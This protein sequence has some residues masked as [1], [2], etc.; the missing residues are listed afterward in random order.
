MKLKAFY[1]VVFL[2]F[3][4]LMVFGQSK[5]I[6][7]DSLHNI[8]AKANNKN[9][10]AISYNNLSKSF[11][12][13]IPDSGLFYAHKAVVLSR[14]I[15]NES[16][17]SYAYLYLGANHKN[18][19]SND[20]ALFYLDKAIDLFEKTKNKPG[21]V[22]AKLKKALI[23]DDNGNNE[24]AIN[25]VSGL[26]ND[27]KT[28]AI[29]IELI[30][31]YSTLGLIHFNLGGFADSKTLFQ[32]AVSLSTK[33]N[34]RYHIAFNK[35]KLGYAM[36]KLGQPDSAYAEYEAALAIATNLKEEILKATI[37][38]L[39]GTY[40]LD[41]SDYSKSLEYFYESLSI[42][43]R[44]NAKMQL[45]KSYT[46][47]GLVY[48]NQKD[49]E[50]A[51][52]NFK[53][54]L[55]RALE[56]NDLRTAGKLYG[57]IG[58]VYKQ[59]K[60]YNKTLDFYNKALEIAIKRNDKYE[61]ARTLG[62][63]GSLSQSMCKYVDAVEYMRRARRIKIELRAIRDLIYDVQNL[64]Y[65]NFLLSTDSVRA[66]LGPLNPSFLKSKEYHQN[67][68]IYLLK[69]CSN[70]VD[71]IDGEK[72]QKLY[73]VGN[74]VWVYIQMDDYKNAF[75][76]HLELSNLEK[77]INNETT[78]ER[79][80]ELEAVQEKLKT[81]KELA[82]SIEREQIQQEASEKRQ[83]LI[84]LLII[85]IGLLLFLAILV[86]RRYQISKKQN[87]IIAEQKEKLTKLDE[88]KNN[89]FTN[90]THEFRT[91][92]TVILGA[93][94]NIENSEDSN[95]IKRN[96]QRLLNLINQ[97]LD[98]SKLED[99]SLKINKKQI[100]AV[101]FTKYLTDSY[102]S[103]ALS[104]NK[105]LEFKS[106]VGEQF[107][108]L[109]EDKYQTIIGNLVSNAVKFTPKNGDIKI[110]TNSDGQQLNISIKDS[111]DG[112]PKDELDRLFDR[113]YQ[114]KG[115]KN[116]KIGSGV[117]L[118]L[119]KE[120]VLQFNGSISV[121]N[122]ENGGAIFTVSL[123]ITKQA[124]KVDFTA[125]ARVGIEKASIEI[126][127]DE[128]EDNNKPILLLVEDEPDIQSFIKA[129]LANNYNLLI[130]NNGEEGIELALANVPDI[131]L[132]DVMMPG[133]DGL[134]LTN[135]L[136][137]DARTSHIP[138]ALLTAKVDLES[139]LQGLKRGADVYLPKPFER[140]E[141]LLQLS[142]LQEQQK[143]VRQ[144]FGA[145]KVETPETQIIEAIE[146]EDEF[147]TKL[148]ETISANFEN[149]SFGI[150]EL[151]ST[152][153]MSRTQ[154][155]RKLKALTGKSA[156]QFVNEFKIEKACELLMLPDNNV[157]E[158]A[159]SLGFADPNY[160]TRVFTKIKGQ[161]PTEFL[162]QHR[163]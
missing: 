39:L 25:L 139:R 111:G 115:S 54:G 116:Q 129:T 55:E 128:I 11:L 75:S 69:R 105:T 117:G 145:S 87:S 61:E 15:K 142:N 58:I 48:L 153:S 12:N 163:K 53:I 18:A 63:L 125:L 92:L 137:N 37:I 70:L 134:E 123:P 41:N 141:L 57:N 67:R 140:E 7:S 98:L 35:L 3:P 157:S 150:E 28:N 42:R 74:L 50:K 152:I 147:I 113:F 84:Y 5:S 49:T 4:V 124:Q 59:Q 51:I 77:Q 9:D 97:I 162:E 89:F 78:T 27:L 20:S 101:A 23:L 76:T 43:Q 151:S 160:F 99:G 104:Q 45:S 119:T 102:K 83:N 31:S 149:E 144:H 8:I 73:S 107:M 71:S 95:L 32:K 38:E 143:R 34:K 66:K 133:K 106:S 36:H 131:I 148:K 40:Y 126:K 30:N 155:H 52:E 120:L 159:Y 154:L 82:L 19:T 13:T 88:V 103:L 86:L 64:G 16:A 68:S 121:K 14:K 33:A 44:L 96:G 112:I 132:S 94:G 110:E 56:Q 60:K 62:N 22:E 80:A 122:H 156:S 93:A 114:V 109:D 10:R 6:N 146:I 26:I 130:A 81:E 158:V 2:M 17:L 108:D 90:I 72:S 100:D 118:A 91:P 65:V 127:D 1:L 29:S 161:S 21:L 136:K 46:N 138:I 135:A 79:I 24:N 85:G 47:I